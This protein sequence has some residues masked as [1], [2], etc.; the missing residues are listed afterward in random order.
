MVPEFY[1]G[2]EVIRQ[3]LTNLRDAP[4]DE[5]WLIFAEVF[6]AKKRAY[7]VMSG[8]VVN[9]LEDHHLVYPVAFAVQHGDYQLRNLINLR[10]IELIRQD[11]ILTLLASFIPDCSVNELR[12]YYLTDWRAHEPSQTIRIIKPDQSGTG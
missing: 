11:R 2:G 12:E 7:G 3:C 9:I 4:D 1:T 8:D 10:L 6:H 5:M